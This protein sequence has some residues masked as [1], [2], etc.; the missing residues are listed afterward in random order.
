MPRA[1]Q[2]ASAD[3]AHAHQGDAAAATTAEPHRAVL[4]QAITPLPLRAP[5]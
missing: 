2:G 1:H 4:H 3:A 5:P